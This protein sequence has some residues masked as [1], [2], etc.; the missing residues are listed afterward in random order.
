MKVFG[1]PNFIKGE[2][3]N[4]ISLDSI[5]IITF[6]HKCY[7]LHIPSL[8]IYIFELFGGKAKNT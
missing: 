2:K 5:K 1:F 7:L 3:N 4:K 8:S 6:I